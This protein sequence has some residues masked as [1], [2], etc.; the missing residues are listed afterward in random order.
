[1]AEWYVH[2]SFDF[3]MNLM[4]FQHLVYLDLM[5]ILD[6]ENALICTCIDY[7]QLHRRPKSQAGLRCRQGHDGIMLNWKQFTKVN[8]IGTR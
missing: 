7:L 4:P 2:P 1:V 8:N 6:L 5:I 3:G